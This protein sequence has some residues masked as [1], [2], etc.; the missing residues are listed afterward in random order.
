MRLSCA[1]AV[2]L[3]GLAAC[4]DGGQ[5]FVDAPDAID[6][7]WF[8]APIDVPDVDAPTDAPIDAPGVDAAV[9]LTSTVSFLPAL[10]TLCGVGFDP[11]DS[12]VWVYPCSGATVDGF[13][14]AGAAAGTVTRPGE[15]ANDVDVT[16][17]TVNVVIGTATVTAGSMIFINGE[18]DA[19][20]VHLPETAS[21]T[22][23]V[24]A[25]GA[26]HVVGGSY[27]PGRDTL[28]LVQDRVAG[29]N[30]NTIA[31]I[32][33]VTGAVVNSFSTLPAFDVNYGDVEVCAATGELFV[34]SSNETTIAR[35]SPTGQLLDE[36]TLPASVTAASGLALAPGGQAWIAS[37]AGGVFRVDG[38][39]CP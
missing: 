35:L 26:S 33:R 11:V 1:P 10:G 14:T 38:L 20:E 4:P 25:F 7:D 3:V 23:L 28:F 29:T 34:V 9:V 21:S 18:T 8:D 12:L 37:T 39:P 13:T 16:F 32:N 19:A 17:A 31:E 27:H 2:L 15:A 6:S 36:H 24:T 22:P 5:T 30:A